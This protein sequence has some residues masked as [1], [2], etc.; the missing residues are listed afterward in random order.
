MRRRLLLGGIVLLTALLAAG[1]LR[2]AFRPPPVPL[3]IAAD[4]PRP[5]F[6]PVYMA[7]YLGYFRAENLAPRF[8]SGPY[9]PPDAAGV[10]LLDLT[11]FL[12][13]A[14]GEAREEV[15]IGVL[16]ARPALY[17]LSTAP[18]PDFG[19]ARLKGATVL[20][21]EPL[22]APETHFAC[23]LKAHGLFLFREVIPVSNLPPELHAGALEAGLAG[24]LVATEPRATRLVVG[25]RLHI[26]ASLGTA[27][28]DFPGAVVV[29][30]RR[31]LAGQKEFLAAFTRA[32]YRAQLYL[33]LYGISD[34]VPALTRFLPD[35]NPELVFALVARLYNDG[36]WAP[37]PV[38]TEEAFNRVT[39]DLAGLRRLQHPVSYAALVDRTLA[40]EALERIRKPPKRAGKQ[41]MTRP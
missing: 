26:V 30:P 23:A 3:Y 24:Y 28:G 21:D 41:E 9:V 27:L 6:L 18:Q 19:Y 29:A 12:F 14:V 39:G 35:L 33:Q 22:T 5:E 15:V 11:S 25:S 20:T 1:A 36:I 38:L 2:L 4:A 37:A 16:N 10:M 34:A 17:L 8:V 13:R 31:C 32:L 40:L 7:D